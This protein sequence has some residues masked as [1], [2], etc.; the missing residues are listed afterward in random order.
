[1]LHSSLPVTNGCSSNTC[2]NCSSSPAIVNSQRAALTGRELP[3]SDALLESPE[4]VLST[5]ERDGS[6]R[7]M[8]PKLAKE[9]G[10]I[11]VA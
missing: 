7:W 6:R 2:S 11:A 3:G 1:M 5:L 8:R 10:G 4:H 9:I